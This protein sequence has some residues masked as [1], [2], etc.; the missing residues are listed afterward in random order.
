MTRSTCFIVSLATATSA[1]S[2]DRTEDPVVV[3]GSSL[4]ALL[5]K[6]PTQIVAFRYVGVWEQIPV[7]VDERRLVD[8][9]V[10]Y[11]S[12]TSGIT[13]MAYAD[14]GTWSGADPDSTFDTNDELVFM[15][16]DVGNRVP[17]LISLPSG[18]L[19]DLA[20]EVLVTDPLA[21]PIGYVYLFLNAGALSQGA[22]KDYVSYTFNL[23]SGDYFATY[24]LGEGPNP[25]NSEVNS[26]F[27]R[28]HFSDRWI[29]DEINI[30][31]GGA[32]GVDVLDRH[33]E[34]FAPGACNR[35]EDTFSNGE[36]AFLTNRDG[37]VRAIRSYEGAN[38]G[39]YTLREHIFYEK[40]HD[41]TTALRV[42]PIPGIMD[43]YDYSP[44]AS[45]MKYTSS[46][47]TV[48][49]LI[50]GN[51][52]TVATGAISWEMVTGNQ[53][54]L[55]CIERLVTDI[56]GLTH[57]SYY[58]DDS[59]PSVTQCT[60]DAYEYGTSGLWIKSALPNT[61]PQFGTYKSLSDVR[62]EYYLPPNQTNIAATDRLAR[63]L[64]PLT[65]TAT[66]L[67]TVSGA[68]TFQAY[69]G[70]AITSVMMRVGALGEFAVH[71]GADGAFTVLAPAG[72]L[73]LAVKYSHWLR[74][75]LTTSANTGV[76][77]T[78]V[79][80][81]AD[82]DNTIA[83]TDLN[84]ILVWFGQPVVQGDLDGSG[85]VDLYDLNTVLTNFTLVGDP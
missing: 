70:A 71:L 19:K 47:A 42:H 4:T 55:V 54:T 3:T 1:F 2:I 75:S 28:Q 17:T 30:F 81:D 74:E 13:T 40:R 61:D 38:S 45:G 64:N 72:P 68:V 62:I 66:S 56:P 34:M 65:A 44:A 18:V 60:G 31:A 58:S 53:G 12:G 46:V 84:T 37:P 77:F 79:N 10:V 21:G 67:R 57:S 22:G 83:V 49:V 29:R 6:A 43:L 26:A 27:Y 51:P 78:L 73:T 82:L 76:D 25:E 24:E 8:L 16:K 15:A 52:E 41:I 80:G 39:P 7:Q 85:I 59:T 23:L 50:D 33:K 36:G 32:T 35:T 48:G 11:N 63:V 69:V 20:L 9:R 14:A 5:A